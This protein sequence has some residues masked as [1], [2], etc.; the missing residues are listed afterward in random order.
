MAL[1]QTITLTPLQVNETKVIMRRNSRLACR[2]DR[3]AEQD[4]VVVMVVHPLGEQEE[5]EQ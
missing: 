3:R 1:V 5:V 2:G 4:R